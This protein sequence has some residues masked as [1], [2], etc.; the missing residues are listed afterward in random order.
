MN[1]RGD[2]AMG[3]AQDKTTHHFRLASDGGAI[4]VTANNPHDAASRRQIQRHLKHIAAMFQEG[5][6]EV[7]MFV[8]GETPDGVATMRSAKDR[9]H[10]RFEPTQNGGRV[11]IQTTDSETLKAVHQF[12]R[13]Q[14][15]E[16]QTGDPL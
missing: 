12:L 15:R 16:H 10:Y 1:A 5:N 11:Q 4:E 3:F 6:F 14:I 8:H 7:P 2:K 9:I 13:F